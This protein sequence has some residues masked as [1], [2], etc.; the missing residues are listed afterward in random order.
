[1]TIKT[2]CPWSTEDPL[3]IA[4]HD[5]EWGAPAH[6]DIHLFEMLTLEGA[7]A[8]LSW[9]L[10]LKKRENYRKAFEGFRP[11]RVAQYGSEKVNELLS[12]PGIV[13]NRRKVESAIQN[14]RCA[15]KVREEY[16]SLDSFLWGFVGGAP[17]QNEWKSLQEVPSR[18]RESDMMSRELQKRGFSFVG[19]TICYSFMQAV[20]MVNDHIVP[21]FRHREV[22]KSGLEFQHPTGAQ[23]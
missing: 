14:A 9:F 12:N 1:M 20:G 3:Y 21:C 18:S 4:Y 2:R 13:R 16:G 6:D 22:K 15:L 23:S 10:I 17:I 5:T 11:D 8:G 19:S 7:Q